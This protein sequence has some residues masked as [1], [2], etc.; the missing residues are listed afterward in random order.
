MMKKFLPLIYAGL[1]IGLL[2]LAALTQ[3]PKPAPANV[4]NFGMTLPANY[5]D[6][7]SLYLVI[8]RPDHTV[9]HVYAAPDVVAAVAAGEEIPYGTQIIIETYDAQ[10]DLL[11]NPLRGSDGHYVAG[12]MQPNI[13]MIEKRD[14]WTVNQLPTPIGVIDWNF[15]SF[16]AQS[17]L[18]S[19]ENRNDC[20]TCHDNGAFR[21]DFV[22]SRPLLEDFVSEGEVQYLFCRLPGRGNCI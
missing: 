10:A 16:D 9:R 7:F 6:D 22:F 21:R 1:V 13:H 11:G 12:A 19:T 20:L 2:V 3:Q 5:R 14:D 17:M 4:P 8:D 18:P 15:G